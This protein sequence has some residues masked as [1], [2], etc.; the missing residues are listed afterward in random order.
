[1][2]GTGYVMRSDDYDRLGGIPAFE[3]LLFADDAL[4][5][6]LMKKSWKAADPR[7]ALA[8]RI[9]TQSESA[10]SPASCP[11]ILLGLEQFADFLE[12]FIKDDEASQEVFLSFG[13]SFLLHYY[14]N[15]YVYALLEACQKGKKIGSEILRQI[16]SYLAKRAP[17]NVSYLSL[18]FKV[19]ALEVLNASFLRP[20]VDHLWKLYY[21]LRTKSLWASSKKDDKIL[22]GGKTW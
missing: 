19:K 7:E 4:C 9:H 21:L 8:V 1:M 5:L 11:S 18:S 12:C 14:R 15:V 3:K 17:R 6:L 2:F 16:E 13:P 10:S 22:I 20:Q